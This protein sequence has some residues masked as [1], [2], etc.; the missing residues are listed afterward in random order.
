MADVSQTVGDRWALLVG[1]DQYLDPNFSTLKYS[2]NDVTVLEQV[3]NQLGYEVIS[4]HTGK[5]DLYS[6]TRDNIEATLIQLCEVAQSNDLLFVHFSC[7]GQLVDHKP[8][9]IAQDTRYHLVNSRSL[10]LSLIEQ[11]M[12]NS[13]AKRLFLSLDACHTGVEMGRSIEDLEFIRNV[14]DLAE[15]FALIAASTAQQRARECPD[16]QHGVYTYYLIEGLQGAAD[17]NQQQFVTV[18]GLQKYVVNKLRHWGVTQGG[19]IQEPTFR[20]E[21]LGDMILA[22]YRE[23]H[24]KV[25]SVPEHYS[26]NEAQSQSSRGLEPSI[27]FMKCNFDVVYLNALGEEVSRHNQQTRLLREDLGDSYLNMILI[28]EGVGHIGSTV[29][30]LGRLDTEV[31]P[32]S[33]TVSSFFLSQ[34]PI[35][36]AQW[37][38]IASMPQVERDLSLNP[39]QF[40]GENRPVESM[41]LYDA[42]EFCARLAALTERP[43]RLPTEVEWE[44]AC[45]A[46]TTT[47]FHF[48]ETITSQLANYD[49]SSAY[50]SGVTGI[51]RQE[52]SPVGSFGVANPYGLYD[53]H[54]NVWEWC[55]GTPAADEK[56]LFNRQQQTGILRGGSWQNH[57][58]SCRS[59]SRY[60]CVPRNRHHSFGFRVALTL[61]LN[62]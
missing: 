24:P 28:P 58:N 25:V 9:L 14:Y 41:S 43:Y 29:T 38:V 20:A 15:G 26:I 56:H 17:Y 37:A 31:L 5:D 39:S 54:G 49:G 16:K 44:Y 47:P 35:S 32:Y 21:G 52:T 51:Y 12:R 34:Y 60:C 7:H 23:H 10:P 27:A 61:P 53:L 4:L 42:T 57:P 13:Q 3:L 30:E 1:I 59:A 2:T 11:Y 18:S 19:L 50:G 6:P 55:C 33:V 46:G 45:R 8:V 22:D 48:G 36:Q 62:F 40:K